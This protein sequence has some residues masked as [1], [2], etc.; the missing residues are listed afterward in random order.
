MASVRN[1]E[2][3]QQ[4]HEI[5]KTL[6]EIHGTICGAVELGNN[7]SRIIHELKEVKREQEFIVLQASFIENYKKWSEIDLSKLDEIEEKEM[8]VVRAEVDSAIKP[9][10]ET[11]LQEA[12][13]LLNDIK[14]VRDMIV[15]NLS[16]CGS[17]LQ[18]VQGKINESN[19]RVGSPATFAQR[20][21][22]TPKPTQEKVN[23]DCCVIC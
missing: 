23:S 3:T 21:P 4:I 18:E 13:K 9:I 2:I 12:E 17:Y 16:T 20:S 1:S 8:Q 7:F 22:T 5:T 6:Q 14:E 10:V 19:Y 11:A 15:E